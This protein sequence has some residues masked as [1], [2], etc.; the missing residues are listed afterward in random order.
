MQEL[1]QPI[2]AAPQP[3]QNR[4]DEVQIF[5]SILAALPDRSRR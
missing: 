2:Q 4:Q 3:V 1:A 5:S